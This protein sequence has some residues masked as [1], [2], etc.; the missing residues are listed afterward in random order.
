MKPR[1]RRPTDPPTHPRTH[2]PT[3]HHHYVP[4]PAPTLPAPCKH[5]PTP[6]EP[7]SR[8]ECM[9]SCGTPMSTVLTPRPEARM[10][11]MV[12]PQA[13]SERTCKQQAVGSR[14]EEGSGWSGMEEVQSDRCSPAGEKARGKHVRDRH[15]AV[16]SPNL[17]M[18]HYISQQ[19]PVACIHRRPQQLTANSAVGTPARRHTSL[20]QVAEGTCWHGI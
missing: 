4:Q 11:P 3:L 2:T 9:A 13:M 14:E 7:T 10:G 16:Q 6:P 12:D 17:S 8:M 15:A 19:Q 18:P 1:H 20:Q 5:L